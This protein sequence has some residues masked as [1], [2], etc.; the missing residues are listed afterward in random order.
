MNVV[1]PLLKSVIRRWGSS[2]LEV[3]NHASSHQLFPSPLRQRLLRLRGVQNHGAAI[4]SQVI[5]ENP[6]VLLEKGSQVFSG[7]RFEGG[8]PITVSAGTV[9]TG[10]IVLTT[11]VGQQNGPVLDV[12]LLVSE[13]V[14]THEPMTL[15]PSYITGETP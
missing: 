2:A 6:W 8:A 14:S 13:S 12:P 1:V 15:R 10:P 3:V 5:F 9:L 7:A 11:R 4:P